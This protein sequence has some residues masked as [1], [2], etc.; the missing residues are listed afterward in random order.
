MRPGFKGQPFE[1]LKFRTMRDVKDSNGRLLPDEERITEFGESLRRFSLDEL[2]QLINVLQ[3]RMSLIGPRPQLMEYADKYTAEQMR[4]HDVRP[5]ITGWAQ[6]HG[7][8]DTTWEERFA[9]DLW[10]VDRC[11]FS[12]DFRILIKTVTV[13]LSGGGGVDRSSQLEYYGERSHRSDAC[14]NDNG[15]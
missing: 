7:R 5:G 8:N 12:L 10:Y 1:I 4:R 3:G 9:Y 15:D 11:S 14:R 6:V 13:V 2:P